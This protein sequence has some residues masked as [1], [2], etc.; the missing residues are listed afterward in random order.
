MG[1]PPIDRVGQRFGRLLVTELEPHRH[2]AGHAMWLCECECGKSAIVSSTCLVKGSTRSCGCLKRE[3]RKAHPPGLKHG[4]C[5][6]PLF[7]TWKAMRARCLNPKATGYKNYGDRGITI[8]PRW[9]DFWRFANDMGERPVGT[10]L[11][12]IDNDGSYPPENCRWATPSEQA[13]N[14]RGRSK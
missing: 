11:D 7:N 2:P 12:R 1:R 14:R 4:G 3:Q 8:D 6:H 10:T 9:S 13:N 5:S